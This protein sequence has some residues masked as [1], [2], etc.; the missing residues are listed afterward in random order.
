MGKSDWKWKGDMG[1]ANWRFDADTRTETTSKDGLHRTQ[2]GQVPIS[3][4]TATDGDTLVTG[5]GILR[6]RGWSDDLALERREEKT[7]ETDKL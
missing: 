3:R 4:T 7:T 6:L 2:I 1:R 5:R